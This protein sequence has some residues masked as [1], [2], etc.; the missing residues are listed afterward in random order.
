MTIDDALEHCTHAYSAFCGIYESRRIF[1]LLMTPRVGYI[2]AK[3]D[4]S[5]EQMQELR[6]LLQEHFEV[7]LIYYDV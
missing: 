2:I 6:T 4:L 1:A 7:P 5:E 3:T